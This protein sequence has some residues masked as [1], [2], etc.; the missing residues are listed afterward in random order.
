MHSQ[1]LNDGLASIGIRGESRPQQRRR[2]RNTVSI[3]RRG[4]AVRYK[5]KVA[6]VDVNPTGLRLPFVH[7][8]RPG[9]LIQRLSK[10]ALVWIAMLWIIAFWVS[11]VKSAG[12]YAHGTFFPPSC[13]TPFF[14]F[15]IY[16]GGYL[17]NIM[18]ITYVCICM[19]CMKILALYYLL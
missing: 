11:F 7:G 15:F 14:F 6:P 1:S 12:E 10:T 19:P 2:A 17:L 3:I 9:R 16:L 18:Y 5:S 8:A 4:R 13:K